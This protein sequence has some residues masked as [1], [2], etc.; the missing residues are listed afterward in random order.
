MQPVN[1]RSPPTAPFWTSSGWMPR[2]T[3]HQRAWRAFGSLFGG[4]G[5]RRWKVERVGELAGLF[6]GLE[7][8][9]ERAP[10]VAGDHEVVP[11]GR[12]S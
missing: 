12:R 6:A 10:L 2:R 4:A 8:R 7:G 9:L 3:F 1:M 5:L 11:G